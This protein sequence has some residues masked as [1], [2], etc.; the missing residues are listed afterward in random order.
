M[1]K[2]V[3]LSLL[4]L[5]LATVG[6]AQVT[7][8][9]T[10]TSDFL[11]GTGNN[12]VIG[13]DMVSMQSKMAT[14]YDFEA[15]TNLPQNLMNHQ[16]VTWQNYV[17]CVGG[18]NG[19]TP[20]NTVYRATQQS[21]GLSTWTTMNPLPVPLTDM[22]VVATQQSL[23]VMGGRNDD[24]ASKKIYVA[25]LDPVD[26]TMGEWTESSVV[27]PY[28]RWGSKAI[29]VHDNIYLIGG[30]S[31]L[32]ETAASKYVYCLKLNSRGNVVS[33]T[34]A[35][36]LPDARNGHAVA[37]YDSKIYVMGGHDNSGVLK[38]T[39][40]CATVNLNGTL[41]SWSTKTAL[42]V[43]LKNHTAVCTNG[44]MAVIGGMEAELPSSTVYYTYMDNSSLAWNVGDAVLSARTHSGASI[45]FGN[46][47][48][49][50]G[51]MNLSGSIVNFTRFA[52]LETGDAKVGKGCFVSLPYDLGLPMKNVHQ[53]SYNIAQTENS[54]YEVLYRLAGEN[55]T[56]GNWISAGNNNPVVID[57]T[58]R[59]IQYM[60]RLTAT[61]TDDIQLED[62]SATMTGYTQLAGN[63]ND[64]SVLP[65]A[66]SPYW[67]TSDITFT[68]GV[69]DID[70][71]VVIYFTK[72]TG[73]NITYAC[74]H[75]NGTESAPILL[76]YNNDDQKM[77]RGVYYTGSGSGSN[78]QNGGVY[79]NNVSSMNYT[80]IENA[81]KGGDNAAVRLRYASQ[82]TF[83]HCTISNSATRGFYL[84]YS[85]SPIISNCT[86]TNNTTSAL[87]L[88]NSNPTVT[89]T[90]MTGSD[91][92]VYIAAGSY[93]SYTD[94]VTS[95][96]NVG[97]Y[98]YTPNRDFTYNETT[99][100]FSN[101]G[102][103]IQM[104]SGTING[105]RT[106][107]K[108]DNGYWV[109][110]GD[111]YIS[112]SN[113]PTLTIAPGNSICL[114]AGKQ[115]KIGDSNDS[116]YG[117]CIY[118]VGNATDSIHFTA[119]NGQSG[120]WG[121][122][123]FDNSS[124]YNSS[125]AL[126]YCVIEKA[127]T[128]IY[129]YKTTQPQ[130]M[131]S[132][133]RKASGSNIG[134]SYSSEINMDECY[135]SNA[136]NGIYLN[137]GSTATVVMTTFENHTNACAYHYDTGSTTNFYTCTMK[138]SNVGV[139][140]YDPNVNIP[141]YAHPNRVTFNNVT[142]PVGINGGTISSNYTWMAN[143]YG[144]FG[145]IGVENNSSVVRWTIDAGSVLRFA[146]GKGIGISAYLVNS[147]S[148]YYWSSS[149]KKVN[150][151]QRERKRPRLSSPPL[152]VNQEVGGGSSLVT[153]VTTVLPRSRC[154][155]TAS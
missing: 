22:A 124:D 109:S 80:V 68:T 9:H 142:S 62:M 114:D 105:N 83:S 20:V 57:Q 2:L 74:V 4:L 85:S 51:G 1:K 10:T 127:S 67:A 61:G 130:L 55:L 41:S 76:T 16:L 135:V 36:N 63:L 115:I 92:G 123:Y 121:G 90:T 52:P 116:S 152:T 70:P 18:H 45:A 31:Y 32:T 144:V 25:T 147:G 27:L 69:H 117:G 39:V 139:R 35:T 128:N 44:I 73:L 37:T 33:C 38:T 98:S 96:N 13:N 46:K 15:S 113:S 82:P 26:G 53:L 72:N 129:L 93:G 43:A 48:F 21:D 86:L 58:K 111:L 140:Y 150:C 65:I 141:V 102:I 47:I 91:Y 12:V 112:G 88:S 132:T 108:K 110:G 107:N 134:L 131:Y 64:I 155:S 136:N 6:V 84:D 97:L 23:I 148:S 146:E 137:Y 5:S 154:S 14:M 29:V 34:T 24:G 95:D 3:L 60:V 11:K 138:N 19:T 120:G 101:N 106:W 133:I 104:A 125:S 118:A 59:A 56:Y 7:L 28:T 153:T 143:D 100:G 87:Y 8:T 81:G 49:F 77:W 40:Y 50:T 54:S 145:C 79:N 99:L 103:D 94:C 75:F 151:M 71:G 122:F 66:N 126:R 119:K 17:F 89:A 149:G 30:A 78:Q 42:P